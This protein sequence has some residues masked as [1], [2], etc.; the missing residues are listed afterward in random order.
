M[1]KV[2][3]LTISPCGSMLRN[4]NIKNLQSWMI[5]LEGAI[6]HKSD[7]DLYVAYPNSSPKQE[8]PFEFENVKYYPINANVKGIINRIRYRFIPQS[9]KDIKIVDSVKQIVDEIKPDLIHVHGTEQSFGLIA[10]I[11]KSIPIVVSIQGLLSP[12]S[13]K[14]YT[15]ISSSSVKR[16]NS[17]SDFRHQTTDK[18][19]YNKLCEA[20]YRERQILK[21]LSH[22][23]GRTKW[24]KAIS[25]MMAPNSSYYIVNEIFR[26]NFAE[27]KW[28][29]RTKRDSLH[30]VSTISSGLYKGY[31]VILETSKLLSENLDIDFDWNVIG[32]TTQDREVLAAIHYTNI[33][34]KDVSVNFLGRK[35]AE[36]I[37]SIMA[38]SDLYIQTSHI[39]NSPN[40]LGEAMMYGMPCLASYVGGTASMLTDQK[41]GVLYSDGDYYGLASLILDVIKHYDRY[42]MMGQNAREVS[43]KRNTTENVYN[44]LLATY[45]Q[46]I[47]QK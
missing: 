43:L 2:L 38:N 46:I 26:E 32:C 37:I 5:T 12:I 34:P 17:F 27:K 40:A 39:E 13:T 11:V 29:P 10:S 7:I 35:N 1:I 8:P 28:E 9:R 19:V 4:N 18:D 31:E 23:I 21:D 24:D 15:G 33:N 25:S 6:K 16:Y 20:S 36:E 47:N 22:V 45:R 42:I 3:W 30:I 41:E 44:E 14:Y